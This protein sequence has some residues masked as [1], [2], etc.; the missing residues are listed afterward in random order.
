MTQ[1]FGHSYISSTVRISERE[2]FLFSVLVSSVVQQITWRKVGYR[3]ARFVRKT[4]DLECSPCLPL[5][6]ART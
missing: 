5:P 2:L 1:V 3:T 4:V 6:L